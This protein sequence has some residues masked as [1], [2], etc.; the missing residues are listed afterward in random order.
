M[1]SIGHA[2]V[3]KVEKQRQLNLRLCLPQYSG[4]SLHIY[5][6][7]RLKVRALQA[8]YKRLHLGSLRCGPRVSGPDKQC[9]ALHRAR[10][11]AGEAG[12]HHEVLQVARVHLQVHNSEP[13]TV[14]EGD[15]GSVR[16]QL[17]QG[18][19]LCVRRLEQDADASVRDG[20]VAPGC[21]TPLHTRGL[22]AAHRRPLDHR[23]HDPHL[24]DARLRAQRLCAPGNNFNYIITRFFGQLLYYRTFLL[25]KSFISGFITLVIIKSLFINIT[26][27]WHVAVQ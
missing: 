21:A 26:E 24:L 8:G 3:N 4:P 22:R 10:D 15:R 12:V 5:S 27:H 20:T 6:T 16:G 11:G 13:V 18:H 1:I 23:G 2:S 17:P 7:G 19:L 9:P 14:R 25:L